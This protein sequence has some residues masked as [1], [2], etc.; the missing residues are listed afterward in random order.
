M[1]DPAQRPADPPPHDRDRRRK[2][3]SP[4]LWILLLAVLVLIGWYALTQRSTR[5][6]VE[7]PPTPIIGDP[8]TPVVEREPERRPTRSAGAPART[9][10]QPADRAA[11]PTAQPEIPYPPAAAR[12]REEGS[13]TLLV[14]V[15]ANG[16]AT[17]VSIAERSG[18]RDLDRAAQ[19]AVRSWKFEPAIKG[20]KP[21][22]SEVR[23]PIDFSLQQ[24]R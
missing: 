3:S 5:E 10:A 21:I 20:G 15:D 8:D 24:P 12:N 18:S 17:D 19:Q 23:V 7:L 22:A 1:Y 2:R 11:R 13:L 4:L 9:P 16:N 6:T 14:Q